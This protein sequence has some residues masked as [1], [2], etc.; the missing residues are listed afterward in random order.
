MPRPIINDEN[1][2]QFLPGMVKVNDKPKG[3]G[4][5]PRDY[6]MY[7]P[8]YMG[9]LCPP[10]TAVDMPLIPKSDWSAR[11]KEMVETKSRLSDIRRNGLGPGKHIPS[12]D[13][14]SSNF[15]WSHSATGAVFMLRAIA[16]AP[17]LRLSAFAVACKVRNF[18]NEGWFGAGALEYIIANGVPDVS[19]WP[20]RSMARANDTAA[21]WENAAANKVSES[22]MDVEPPVWDRDLSFAQ[23]MTCLLS[24][25]PVIGDFNWWRHSVLLLDPVEVEPGSFGVGMLNSWS[26]QWGDIGEAVLQGSKAIPDGATAPR[27]VTGG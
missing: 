11:I 7:P 25:I 9:P 5:I 23:V 16:N 13:Q 12:L 2:R 17:Y 26:D 24:R 8:G 19:V 14:G 3:H 4:L 18:A 10:M 22:W 6:S 15:C 21:T 1:F 20:E 27:V